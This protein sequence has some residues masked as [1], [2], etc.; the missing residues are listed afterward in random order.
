MTATYTNDPA[1]N[2][3]DRVRL[4]IDDR[5]V[6]TETDA[7]LTDEE[8]QY[9][10]DT[11]SNILLAAAAAAEQLSAK[12]AGDPK[13]KKVG[14]LEIDYGLEG[15]AATFKAVAARLR[16][17]VARR[18]GANLF[19]GGLSQAKKRTEKAL[20]DK[21]QPSFTIGQDDNK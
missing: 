9:Y 8:I 18:G 7:L 20:T 6:T 19:A 4:E 14:P 13:K 21:V 5:D 2:Q 10:I 3:I 11:H 12:F 16:A 17:Q 1:N 15:R